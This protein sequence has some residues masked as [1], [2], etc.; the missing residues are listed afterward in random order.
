MNKT[1]EENEIQNRETFH[2][3][4]MLGS[5][6]SVLRLKN[7][8]LLVCIVSRSKLTKHIVE[9]SRYVVTTCSIYE[10]TVNTVDSS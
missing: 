9:N 3:E 7:G 1:L 5:W 2:A 6:H 4:V 10:C 8:L